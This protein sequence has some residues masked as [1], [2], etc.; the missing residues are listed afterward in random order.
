MSPHDCHRSGGIAG[1]SR[2]MSR[3]IESAR[4]GW[5]SEPNYHRHLITLGGKG[6]W[7]KTMESS[8]FVY[9]AAALNLAPFLSRPLQLTC[10]NGLSDNT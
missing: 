3:L 9:K 1:V 7:G 4:L 8:T 5:N 2:R 6:Y 10:N